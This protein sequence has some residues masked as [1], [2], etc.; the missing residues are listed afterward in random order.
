MIDEV[1]EG[2]ECYSYPDY[3][4]EIFAKFQN[5]DKD[6]LK[7]LK[8][9]YNIFFMSNGI[10][11]VTPIQL[12]KNSQN[13]INGFNIGVEDDGHLYFKSDNWLSINWIDSL[14][15]EL[16]TVKEHIKNGN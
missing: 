10:D 9:E 6:T 12:I 5:W 14:I 13:E 7:Q 4:L 2:K 11:S 1:L 15:N 3:D 16:Q 8:E